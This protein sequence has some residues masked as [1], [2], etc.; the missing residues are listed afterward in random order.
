MIRYH[1]PLLPGR[2]DRIVALHDEA[3]HFAEFGDKNPQGR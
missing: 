1:N 2:N 3:V